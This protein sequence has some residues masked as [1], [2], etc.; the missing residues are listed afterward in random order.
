MEK[1]TYVAV[2]NKVLNSENLTA[3][4]LDKVRALRDSVAKRNATKSNAPTKA[5]KANAE[6]AEKVFGAMESDVV[7]TNADIA[8]LVPELEGATPQKISPLM[9]ILGERVIAEKVKGKAT[10]TLA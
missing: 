8:G 1:L 5:Q 3:E 7:Y 6:L 10:Y 9:K 4:E 2:L